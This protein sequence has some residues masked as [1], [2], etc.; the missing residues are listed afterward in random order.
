MRIWKL[1]AGDIRFQRK[2]GF[3]LVYAIFTAVYLLALAAVPE[4]VRQTVAAVMIFSDPAA[5]G[6]FFMGA[7][8]LLEKGQRVN[9]A[10]AVSPIRVW[11]YTAAKLL[12]L[13]LIGLVVGA[14]LAVAGGIRSLPLC[15]TGVLPASFFCSACGLIAA[16]KSRT[17]NQ[18]ALFA[19]PFELFLMIPPAL[20]L[21]GVDTPVLMAHPGAAAAWLIYGDPPSGLLCVLSLAG[22][23]V[24]ALWLCINTVRRKFVEMGG[25]VA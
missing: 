24:F 13:A 11:E 6:L 9:C 2:Y 12:S 21:F 25:S 7:I 15:L 17:L 18:F 14:V 10:L 23:C 3:Y 19:V 4:R 1:T 22:W 20:L 5:L 16:M 8:I